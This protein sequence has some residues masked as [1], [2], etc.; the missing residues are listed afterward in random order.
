M[1]ITSGVS[2]AG[3][4]SVESDTQ[5]FKDS[6]RK[7][8]LEGNVKVKKDDTNVLSPRAVVE[9]DPKTNKVDKVQ[10]KDNAYSYLLKDKKSMK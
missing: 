9:I 10:F 7:I 4:L 2:F 5:E 3:S 1:Y 8:Y 6:D